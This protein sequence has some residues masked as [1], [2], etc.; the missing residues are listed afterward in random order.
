MSHLVE[1]KEVIDFLGLNAL[2]VAD[3]NLTAIQLGVE[4][5]IEKVHCRRTFAL[6]NHKERYDGT[7]SQFLYVDNYPIVSLNKLC[8]YTDDAISVKNTTSAHSSIS[9][10]STGITLYSD[11]ATTTLLFSSYS[12]FDTLVGAINAVSG[13]VA[14][15][16]S[17]LYSAYPSNLLLEKFGLQCSNSNIVYLEMPDD[18]GEDDFEVTPAEGRIYLYSGFP[19]GVRNVFVDYSAGYAEIPYDLQLA[20]LILIKYIYQRR[21]EESFGV[22][23]Y[24]LSGISMT[25]EQDI[26]LQAKQILAGYTRMIV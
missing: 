25:F 7:G 6:T 1:V 10:S 4:Q 18:D 12:T 21:I 22:S 26:P 19:D 5:W 11:G 14:S 17:P 2:T 15:L 23:S 3:K 9:V 16:V 8:I 20:T 13:W 24:S